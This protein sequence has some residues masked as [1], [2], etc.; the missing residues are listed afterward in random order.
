M[1]DLGDTGTG[2]QGGMGAHVG[3]GGGGGGLVE[4]QFN[5][6]AGWKGLLGSRILLGGWG[7]ASLGAGKQN[8]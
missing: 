3:L 4:S 2:R 1:E 5:F 8:C 7:S 6:K